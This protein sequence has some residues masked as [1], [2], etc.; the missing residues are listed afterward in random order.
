[1]RLRKALCWGAGLALAGSLF[2]QLPF[3][4]FPGVEYRLGDIPLPQDWQERTEWTFAQIGR[5]HV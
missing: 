1:M 5:A 2:A 4:E 3:R